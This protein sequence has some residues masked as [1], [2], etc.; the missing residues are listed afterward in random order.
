MLI[1]DQQAGAKCRDKLAASC[2][3]WATLKTP[4]GLETLQ[5]DSCMPL[6][7]GHSQGNDDAA[8]SR[9]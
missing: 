6:S 5:G 3:V 4:L 8:N 7:N 1:A 9:T 2:K